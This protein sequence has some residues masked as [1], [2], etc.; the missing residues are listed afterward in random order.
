MRAIHCGKAA[1]TRKG[2]TKA[3]AKTKVP[4]SGRKRSPPAAATS[5]VPTNGAVQV[6]EARTKVTPSSTS[7]R[8]PP[9]RFPA[10]CIAVRFAGSVSWIVSKNDKAKTTKTTKMPRLT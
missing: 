3:R 9:Y 4:S 1:K 7:P 8:V 5:S 2:E 10:A 6:N